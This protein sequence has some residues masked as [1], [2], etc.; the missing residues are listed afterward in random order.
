MFLQKDSQKAAI[1]VLSLPAVAGIYAIAQIIVF[2]LSGQKSLFPGVDTFMS[3]LSS[4]SEIIAGL[5]GTTLAGYTFFLSRID[6]LMAADAT[7]DYVVSSIKNRFRYLIWYITFHVLITLFISI[8]LMY[9]PTPAEEEIS[10]F[11]R[12]FCNE[13][14]M[15]LCFSI[16]LILR[17]SILVI[18]PNC[19]EKEAAKL[20][21][22]ISYKGPAGSAT[23]FIALYDRIETVCNQR[24]P[25]NVLAQIHKNK[26]MRFDYTIT[27]LREQNLLLLPVAQ[28]L[29]RIHHYYAC[30]INCP[31]MCVTEEMCVLARRVLTVLE[32]SNPSL[33]G[34]G[35]SS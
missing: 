26:G 13:F 5:Y 23:E 12:L 22:R 30:M 19:V 31:S 1:A 25:A 28:D 4:C 7:L 35:S 6:A 8:V 15:F 9:V 2:G 24:L 20:K 11:Y 18:N 32:P 21:K 16:V 3:I 29:T 17:Y 33:L 10:Y 27:L 14:L 34:N